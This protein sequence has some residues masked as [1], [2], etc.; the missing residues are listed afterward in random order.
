M[1]QS[2]YLKK[3]KHYLSP[4]GREDRNKII[5]YYAELIGDKIESG[6][7]E[8]EVLKSLGEPQEL[9]E[10]ILSESSDYKTKPKHSNNGKLSIG[11]IIGFSALIPFVI[12]ALAVLYVLSLSFIITAI[13]CQLGGI[14]YFIGA[15]FILA[16]GFA[17]ALFQFGLCLFILAL[18]IFIAFG[19]W[20]FMWLCIKI[21]ISIFN[22]YKKTYI[23]E[24]VKI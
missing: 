18:G 3:L 7:T 21:T 11:R 1:N 16:S 24:T 8:Q 10:K 9:A 4:L 20:K 23:K 6:I 5:E 14:C 12:I 13:A 19:A 22:T 2:E 15:F 17:P